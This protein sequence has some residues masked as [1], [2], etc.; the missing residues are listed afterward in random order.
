MWNLVYN[1]IEHLQPKSKQKIVIFSYETLLFDILL[2]INGNRKIVNV[3]ILSDTPKH[4]AIMPYKP[5]DVAPDDFLTD[6][7]C[8]RESFTKK[9]NCDNVKDEGAL[10]EILH[11]KYG[12]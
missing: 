7:Y 3:F 12:K 8:K 11:K 6:Y 4:T 9:Y 5:E 10:V 1:A 2:G